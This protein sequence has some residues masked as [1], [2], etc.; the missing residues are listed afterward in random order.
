MVK[1]S[2]ETKKKRI[3]VASE[4]PSISDSGINTFNSTKKRNFPTH[5]ISNH[6]FPPINLQCCTD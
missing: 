3:G 4:N 2:E 5:Q 1:L 6:S